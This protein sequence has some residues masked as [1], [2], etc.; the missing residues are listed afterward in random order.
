MSERVELSEQE[1][2][3]RLTPEQY[4][5]LRKKG[6]EPAFT[7][8]YWDC[9][10]PGLYRCAACEAPL[11]RS[12]TKYDSG[13]GWPSFSQPADPDA[14]RFEEDRSFFM[15]RVEVLCNNCGSHLGHVF[16]DGPG[17]TGQR[18]CIN[19]IALDLDQRNL[20]KDG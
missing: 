14:V 1:W 19:S 13:T 16:D 4:Q 7:G 2:R 11:F 10:E 6:T 17:P 5:V 20:D 8:G 15:R 12:D 18:Y 9:K 3:E